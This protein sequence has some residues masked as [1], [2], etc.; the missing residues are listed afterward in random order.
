M[1]SSIISCITCDVNEKSVNMHLFCR[2]FDLLALF[3]VKQR[4]S[5]A[6]GAV[7]HKKRMF[8]VK[9]GRFLFRSSATCT[10]RSCFVR[11]NSLNAATHGDL[12]K[13]ANVSRETGANGH[14]GWQ[15]AREKRVF[16]LKQRRGGQQSAR[17]VSVFHVKRH[18]PRATGVFAQ[19]TRHV[20]RETC[21]VFL[22]VVYKKPFCCFFRGFLCVFAGF[23]PVYSA[24]SVQ[25]VM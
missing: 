1:F 9:Q 17:E 23:S 7:L 25:T 18:E 2:F 3:H 12:R 20:S 4:R 5:A 22:F 11:N 19:K 24:G 14:V 6:A 13:K 16:C 10:K 21:L 8:H 15:P